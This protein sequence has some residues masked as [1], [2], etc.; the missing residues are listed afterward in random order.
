M[1]FGIIDVINIWKCLNYINLE[2]ASV[3]VATMKSYMHE[4]LLSAWLIEVHVS[5]RLFG[6]WQ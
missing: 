1:S 6:A 3:I 4:D 5:G 2:N